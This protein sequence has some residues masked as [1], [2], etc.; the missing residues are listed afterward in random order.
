M[1]K[2]QDGSGKQTFQPGKVSMLATPASKTKE[3]EQG[4]TLVY[5]DPIQQHIALI[6]F[7]GW[8]C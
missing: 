7:D 6:S 2:R 8:L 4:C 5:L 1:R 3:T